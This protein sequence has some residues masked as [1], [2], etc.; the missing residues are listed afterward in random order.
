VTFIFKNEGEQVVQEL[1]I[2][3]RTGKRIF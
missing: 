3:D 1:P 2:S